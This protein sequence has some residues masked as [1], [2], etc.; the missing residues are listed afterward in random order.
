MPLKKITIPP[1]AFTDVT[2]YK[3]G[4]RWVDMDK[5]RFREDGDVQKLGGWVQDSAQVFTGKARTM[6]AWTS[7]T[8][9]DMYA[10]GTHSHMYSNLSYGSWCKPIFRC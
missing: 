8:G 6:Q 9:D 10:V 5:V 3:A 7:L 2:D 4:P 1:G